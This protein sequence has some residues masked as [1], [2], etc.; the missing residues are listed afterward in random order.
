MADSHD[1]DSSAWALGQTSAT[2]RYISEQK[3]LLAAFENNQSRS[4]T[5]DSEIPVSWQAAWDRLRNNARSG[6]LPSQPSKSPENQSHSWSSSLSKLHHLRAFCAPRLAA[7]SNARPNITTSYETYEYRRLKHH[8][9]HRVIILQ[10]SAFYWDQLRVSIVHVRFSKTA[11][12]VYE[13]LSYVCGDATKD[14]V[15]VEIVDQNNK[16]DV[17]TLS[18]GQNLSIALRHL[19]FADKVRVLWCDALSINQQDNDEKSSEILNMSDIYRRAQRVVVW[20]GPEADESKTAL[21]ALGHLGKQVDMNWDWDEFQLTVPKG[22]DPKWAYCN[23]PI[24]FAEATWLAILALISRTWFQRLWV[25][26]EATLADSNTAIARVP[27]PGL[28][29]PTL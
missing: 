26:Q 22:K 6:I 20:L 19:R 18:I 16:S 23:Y 15:T 29:A 21:T 10:P 28:L 27:G 25:W 9:D 1:S 11:M 2:Q 8:D 17:R 13:A 5:L 7:K 3:A 14:P 24:P 12:P 4:V